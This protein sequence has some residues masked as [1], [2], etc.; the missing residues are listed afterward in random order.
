LFKTWASLPQVNK[1]LF[2]HVFC[3][4]LP[5]LAATLASRSAWPLQNAW[6]NRCK[7]QKLLS[8]ADTLGYQTAAPT[9]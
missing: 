7:M 9:C 2:F 3:L 6:A 8:Q 4:L 1:H 5:D